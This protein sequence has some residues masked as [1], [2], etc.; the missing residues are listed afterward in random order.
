MAVQF[1]VFKA[2]SFTS[3]DA[4]MSRVADFATG[5]GRDRLISISHSE[6]NNLA[7]V[8]VWYWE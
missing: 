3:W 1:E 4:L 8:V 5:I 6:D 2:G 7:V